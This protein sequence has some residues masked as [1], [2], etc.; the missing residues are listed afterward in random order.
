MNGFDRNRRRFGAF[1]VGAWFAQYLPTTVQGQDLRRPLLADM[2]SHYAMFQLDPRT[3]ELR[4]HM[5]ETGTALLAWSLVDDAY[6]LGLGPQGV[7]QVSTPE[8][9]ELWSYFRDKVTRYDAQLRAWNLPKVLT[10]ADVDAALSG[11]PH[12]VMASESANFL[13]GQPEKVADA[14]AM[15]LR[16]LQLVHYIESP[17][18]DR[19]TEVHKIKGMPPVALRVI[20]ECKRAGM[21][22]DLA[23]CTDNFVDAAL[24]HSD[25]RMI[26]S[27]S[28]ISRGGGWRNYGH[29]AR[30]LSPAQ[31]RKIA[32]HGGVVG[33]WTAGV[34]SDRSYPL[35]SVS[36]YADEIVRMVDLIGPKSVGFGTDI[37][38]TGPTA[39]MKEYGQLREV[40]N[41]LARRGMPEAVLQD[42]CIGNYA[43]V[44]KEAMRSRRAT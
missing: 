4:K 15:G 24:Q 13:E 11:Q 26:W 32:A 14:H 23:H 41:Q 21:L 12:V 28:W 42:V 19:Q 5:E 29:V 31:A 22:V 18:G 33:L 43:R 30:S 17:L 38:G 44:L 27:H 9:G 8:P 35:R 10:P 39:I 16:H 3:V 2:H 6:W 40:A 34:P 36:S 37:E 1:A 7:S 20:E 25:A